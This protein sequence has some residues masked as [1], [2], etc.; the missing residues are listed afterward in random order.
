MERDEESNVTSLGSRLRSLVAGR[1]E[2]RTDTQAEDVGLARKR[3]GNYGRA[4]AC[5]SKV[6]VDTDGPI[7]QT[8]T[9]SPTY[10]TSP[11]TLGSGSPDVLQAQASC[12]LSRDVVQRTPPSLART[13]A[14]I[15]GPLSFTTAYERS[16][17]RWRIDLNDLSML[18]NFS[19]G[20][21]ATSLLTCQS[22]IRNL[23]Q[24]RQWSYL[25]YVPLVYDSHECVAAATDC[26]LAKVS[27]ILSPAARDESTVLRL[28]S[29]ALSSLRK[30][31]S[32]RAWCA[33]AE[34]LCAV[35]LLSLYELLEP[36][37]DTASMSHLEGSAHLVR[38]RG[39]QRFESELDKA[40]FAAHIGPTVSEALM[41][42]YHCYLERQEWVDL[43]KSVAQESC[44][45]T[46]RS[47]LVIAARVIM[48]GVPGL[49]HDVGKA[50]SSDDLYDDQ[51][52]NDLKIRC[53][54]LQS[55]YLRWMADYK[56]YC[57]QASFRQPTNRELGLR[58]EVFG[59]TLECLI[60][61][62][63]FLSSM[64]MCDAERVR[65]EVETQGLVRLLLDIADQTSSKHSCLFTAHENS[66]MQVT[67]ATRDA[68][69]M[70]LSGEPEEVR[71]VAMRE[72]F[73]M[74][75]DALR[76][77][78]VPITYEQA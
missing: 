44:S 57:L 47:G 7:E 72:R 55:A 20:K 18:T 35:Q 36:S 5:Q 54:E 17:S 59:A 21:W 74:F 6:H 45:L 11:P 14:F 50:L 9:D 63:R 23:M 77:D 66:A 68:F 76:T 78:H 53:R 48:L 25:E 13:L 15:P 30:A 29:R 60:L 71:R 73:S 24:D 49:W 51:V 37:C 33:S 1:L 34:V 2:T 8:V 10:Q 52:L 62:K 40:L 61:V 75:S 27:S 41:G 12:N 56:S 3:R 69:T 28:Y 43:Y 58:R 38:H 65:L 26:I 31:L 39:T 46:D 4:N 32:D 42:D 19:L 64:E 16:R 67:I 70:D 22:T